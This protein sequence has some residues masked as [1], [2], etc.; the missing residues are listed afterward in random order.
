[1]K[2]LFPFLKKINT[3]QIILLSTF[4]LI[5]T[6]TLLLCLPFSVAE[7]RVSFSTAFF[8]S[9]SACCVTGLVVADTATH[10]T[11]FGQAVILFLIQIGGIGVVTIAVLITIFSGRKISLM[12]RSTLQDAVNAP[13]QA[14]LARLALFIIKGSLLIEGIGTLCLL[15]VFLPRHGLKGIWMA[16]FHSVSAFCNA[17]F[18]INGGYSSLTFYGRD[19]LLNIVIMAL[20]IVGGI[21]FLTWDDLYRNG[22]RWRRWSLQTRIIL[23]TTPCLIL[24]P[25][26]FLL[27]DTHGSFLSALF[28]SVT[29]RTAGFNTIDLLSLSEASL[30]LMCILMLVGGSPGSTAG[31]IKTTTL[32]VLV[33]E[34]K[35]LIQGKEVSA[36]GRRFP[37]RVRESSLALLLLY[38]GQLLLGTMFLS[39]R[40]GLPIL[41]CLF[42]CASALGTVG[43]SLGVTPGLHLSSKLLLCFC[44]YFGR[45]GG[46]TLAYAVVSQRSLLRYPE[47]R[48][49][50][51]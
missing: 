26:L 45:V 15:P 32:F 22:I 21:G 17:G 7:G 14:G 27:K 1:M 41:A 34:V 31:G 5:M 36:F 18:D 46:L 44:M 20:I 10:W 29:T 13:Q 48:I 24:F 25:A 47:E 19:P 35:S 11:L 49:M 39:V 12:Q 16:L 2:D 9:V 30:F 6:G 4:A 50:V 23:L 42:E 8:T 38:G 3:F 40:E 51:G 28:Q 43:L 33:C 37:Q